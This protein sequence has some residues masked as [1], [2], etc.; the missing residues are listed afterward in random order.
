MGTKREIKLQILI[1]LLLV[2]CILVY[3]QSDSPRAVQKPSLKNFFDHIGNYKIFRMIDLSSDAVKMLDLNDY[4]FADYVGPNGKVNLYI[5]YYYTANKAYA[6]HSPLICYPSQGWQIDN[7]PTSKTLSVGSHTINY[8][9][10][11]T[12][13]GEQKELVLY[14]YQSG[15]RTNTQIYKN[16]IDMGYNK[17]MNNS[18]EHAFVR[19]SLSLAENSTDEEGEKTATDFIKAFY[20]QFLKF[21]VANKKTPI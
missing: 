17:L 4:I 9:E 7:R 13:L 10:I 2:T 20:P 11:V 18:E 8:E 15:S 3:S 6:S 19:V 1:G 21:I 5:G 14:W 16:K 12:S